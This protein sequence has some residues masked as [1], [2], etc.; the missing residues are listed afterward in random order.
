MVSKKEELEAVTV[1][2]VVEAAPTPSLIIVTVNEDQ[3]FQVTTQG[4]GVSVLEV[5]TILRIAAKRVEKD[6]GI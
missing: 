3:S 4:T 2:E 5:P 6:L 1:D